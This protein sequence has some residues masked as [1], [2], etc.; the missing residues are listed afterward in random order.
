MIVT[1]NAEDRAPLDDVF[2]RYET[3]AALESLGGHERRNR[4][5]FRHDLIA[6][7]RTHGVRYGRYRWRNPDAPSRQGEEGFE[8]VRGFTGVRLRSE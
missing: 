5:D 3:W 7:L 8:R 2:D 4:D 1:G 6:A